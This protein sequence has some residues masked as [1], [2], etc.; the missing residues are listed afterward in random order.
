MSH[1]DNESPPL[2]VEMLETYLGHKESTIVIMDEEIMEKLGIFTNDLVEI[3]GKR[4]TGA[5]CHPSRLLFGIGSL[6]AQSTKIG[7]VI[8]MNPLTRS[9]VEVSLG[10]RVKIRKVRARVVTKVTLLPLHTNRGAV[11]PKDMQRSSNPI[12][13][14]MGDNLLARGRAGTQ[15]VQVVGATESA[16]GATIGN[17]N[18]SPDDPRSDRATTAETLPGS[19]IF[20]VKP[21]KAE[22]EILDEDSSN[23]AGR[24]D[25]YNP[26]RGIP[27][28]WADVGLGGRTDPLLEKYISLSLSISH[29]EGS[30]FT[31]FESRISEPQHEKAQHFDFGKMLQSLKDASAG[32]IR[33][34]NEQ[35]ANA[36]IRGLRDPMGMLGGIETKSGPYIEEAAKIVDQA[37]AEW[38]DAV[39]AGSRRPTPTDVKFRILK[40]WL[41][42]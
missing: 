37:N 33:K 10:E 17:I 13:F 12:V 42:I 36:L 15:F 20:Y 8:R 26:P 3:T 27:V 7:D 28:F 38:Q 4:T 34:M 35:D 21:M 32:G 5:Y 30:V 9:N 40:K 6:G 39:A 29:Y 41:E 19:H 23:S 22:F 24:G 2:K 18:Y 11:E 14:A 1:Q 16:D 25:S 31:T